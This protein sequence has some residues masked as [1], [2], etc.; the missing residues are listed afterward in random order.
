MQLSFC[1]SFQVNLALSIIYARHLLAAL[2]SD[3]PEGQ[4][5]NV[6]LLDN[7]DEAQL[8]GLLDII[9]RMEGKETFEKV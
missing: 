9:Q 2:L 5:I 3:W 1:F 8:I 7:C 6:E 4:A